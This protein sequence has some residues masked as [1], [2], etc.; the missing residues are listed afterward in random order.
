MT[1]KQS[2]LFDN[3]WAFALRGYTNQTGWYKLG[4]TNPVTFYSEDE[5]YDRV[6]KSQR[7]TF[8]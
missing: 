8:Q 5:A 2:V 6:M 1:D 7:A 4:S 3:G